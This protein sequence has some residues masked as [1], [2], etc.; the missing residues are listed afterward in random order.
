[1]FYFS[2][3][4]L[5]Q[6][7]QAGQSV[8]PLACGLTVHLAKLRIAGNFTVPGNDCQLVLSG[9]QGK[10]GSFVFVVWFTVTVHGGLSPA[11]RKI[12]SL[13]A[14]PTDPTGMHVLGRGL[15]GDW[16]LPMS[17]GVGE[18]NSQLSLDL[19]WVAALSFSWTAFALYLR[20]SP[21]NQAVVRKKQSIF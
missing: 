20:R 3:I 6:L 21:A 17:G 19:S 12:R 16:G 8:R 1:M 9:R 14:M 2:F 18:K 4:R 13:T 7:Q 15:F 10:P 11:E 5:G